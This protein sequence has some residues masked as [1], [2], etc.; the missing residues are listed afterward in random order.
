MVWCAFVNPLCCELTTQSPNEYQQIEATSEKW[1]M[2]CLL[3]SNL[4][5]QKN[6]LF[7]EIGPVEILLS[8]LFLTNLKSEKN[9]VVETLYR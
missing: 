3:D 7:I 2:C 6:R 8:N 5:G 1:S 4:I 9:V